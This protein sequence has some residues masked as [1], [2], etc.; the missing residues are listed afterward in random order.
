MS[1]RS[2]RKRVMVTHPMTRAVQSGR[3]TRG[4]SVDL[5]GALNT[6]DEDGLVLRSLMRA[7]LRLALQTFGALVGF[8]AAVVLMLAILARFRP[9]ALQTK[10]VAVPL[11]WWLLGVVMFPILFIIAQAYVSRVERLERRF[12]SLNRETRPRP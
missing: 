8:L 7:Q 3:S 4:S 2:P 1:E 10:L 9:S 6:F 12:Q 5:R 11:V